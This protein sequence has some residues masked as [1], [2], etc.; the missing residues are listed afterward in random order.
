MAP[1]LKTLTLSNPIFLPPAYSPALIYFGRERGWWITCNFPTVF[2]EKTETERVQPAL[3][4]AQVCTTRGKASG[5]GKSYCQMMSGMGSERVNILWGQE[6]NPDILS[7]SLNTS[8]QVNLL[9]VHQQGPYGERY[10]L[11]GHF[12]ISLDI[13][14]YPKGHKKRAS[15]H[16]PQNWGP[17][18]KE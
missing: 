3:L 18:R 1:K 13:S 11:T 12:Y 6:R 10:P 17:Y 9:Q 14:L 5:T 4:L 2:K 7:F 8:W 16:V 15:L